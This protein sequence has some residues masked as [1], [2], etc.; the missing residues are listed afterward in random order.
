MVCIPCIVIPV[1]LWVFHKYIQP[2]IL[3][4]WNPWAKKSVTAD[5]GAGEGLDTGLEKSEEYMYIQ[6]K[7]KENPVMVFSKTTCTYCKMAKKVLDDIGVNYAVEEIDLRK[8][9]D[10]LQDIFAKITDAR[11]VP[12]VY[13]GGKCIGGGSETWTIHNQGRLIPLLKEAKASFKKCD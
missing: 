7:I 13:V 4:F 3:K 1:L 12:R 8:D 11:T 6:Q 5:D 10:K 9:T 2:F